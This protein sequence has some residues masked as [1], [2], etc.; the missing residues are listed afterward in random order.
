MGGV[1]DRLVK[2]AMRHGWRRGVM[3]GSQAWMA[4]GAAALGLRVIRRM[5]SPKPVVITERLTP[6]RALVIRH[7]RRGE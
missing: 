2:A 5:A 4:L 1:F 7:L 6:G 3:G